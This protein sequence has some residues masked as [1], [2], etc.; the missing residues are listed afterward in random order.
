MKSDE[1][2]DDHKTSS[3]QVTYKT[4]KETRETIDVVFHDGTASNNKNNV[5]ISAE[6]DIHNPIH[7]DINI[8]GRSD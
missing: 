8:I 5:Y 3:V 7:I 2:D 6:Y 1:G 4:R